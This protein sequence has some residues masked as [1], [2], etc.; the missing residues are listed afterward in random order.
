MTLSVFFLEHTVLFDHIKYSQSSPFSQ[1]GLIF[2][3]SLTFTPLGHPYAAFIRIG[4]EV[5]SVLPK[6]LFPGNPLWMFV[7]FKFGPILTHTHKQVP[8][9]KENIYLNTQKT[10]NE[11]RNSDE[12]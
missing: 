6:A 10:G 12:Y 1:D 7:C 8:R 2:I 11:D 4:C 5:T 9:R 3:L